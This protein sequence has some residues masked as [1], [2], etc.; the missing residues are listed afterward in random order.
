MIKTTET[1]AWGMFQ[2]S[3][4]ETESLRNRLPHP[5]S[6]IGPRETTYS[7]QAPTANI[8]FLRPFS[9]DQSGMKHK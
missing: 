6:H 8:P 1:C 7:K 5:G 2:R 9:P 3:N 4:G